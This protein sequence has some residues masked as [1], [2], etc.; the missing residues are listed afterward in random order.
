MLE[1]FEKIKWGSPSI[2]L[3]QQRFVEMQLNGVNR[4]W[5]SELD[6]AGV[7]VLSSFVGF[8][9]NDHFSEAVFATFWDGEFKL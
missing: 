2:P 1:Q 3:S 8:D 6:P 9:E 5:R 7:L 4:W